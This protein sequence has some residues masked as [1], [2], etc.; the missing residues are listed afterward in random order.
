MLRLLVRCEVE[1]SQMRNFVGSKALPNY[2]YHHATNMEEALWLLKEL[3]GECK[4]IAGCTDFIPAI[5]RG[6]WSFGD[7][8][9]VID[10]LGIKELSS[11]AK[12]G[13]LIK[14][15]AAIRLS[16]VAGS[17]TIREHASVLADAVSEIG[18]LQ[19]RNSGTIGGN[20]CTASPAADTAPPLLVLDANVKVRGIG[21]EEI[22]PLTKFFVGPGETILGSKEMLTEIQFP[23]VKPDERYCWIKMGRRNVFTL[24]VISLATRVKVKD[25]VFDTVRIALGAVAPTPM[26]ATEAERYLIGK[27]K[28][29]HVIDEGCKIVAREVKPISDVRA[30][31]EYRKDMAYVLTK[32]ALMACLK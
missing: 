4:I 20:L 14:L 8:L 23:S 19:I 1:H 32:R 31:A 15:G 21:K 6:A 22:V 16:Q 13:D 2:V 27:Q 26:R 24:S 18:S 25:G 11:I 5:R 17:P 30:S 9:N 28:S 29:A 12:D 3:K 7:G 10:I